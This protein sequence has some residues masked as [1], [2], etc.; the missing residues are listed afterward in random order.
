MS[1]L[2]QS[3]VLA[4]VCVPCEWGDSATACIRQ[5]HMKARL[6][7]IASL[8]DHMRGQFRQGHA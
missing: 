1:N 5:K 3:W 6:S 8:P 2:A 4:T 7:H